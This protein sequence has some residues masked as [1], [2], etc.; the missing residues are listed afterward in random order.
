MDQRVGRMENPYLSPQKLGLFAREQRVVDCIDGAR[1]VRDL[2]MLGGSDRRDF[3]ESVYRI[4]Y[5]L[6]ELEMIRFIASK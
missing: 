2:F 6:E 5:I 4:L 1:T 3:E